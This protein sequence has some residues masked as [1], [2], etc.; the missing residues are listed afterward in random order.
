MLLHTDLV[1]RHYMLKPGQTIAAKVLGRMRLVN[2]AWLAVCTDRQLLKKVHLACEDGFAVDDMFKRAGN[3]LK[4]RMI[5][6]T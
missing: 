5:G 2:R 6:N 1:P 4:D 3:W